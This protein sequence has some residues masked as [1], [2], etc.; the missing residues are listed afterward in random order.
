MG[1][2][3]Y[4]NQSCEAVVAAFDGNC[5]ALIQ[6]WP[7]SDLCPAECGQCC[8]EEEACNTNGEGSCEYAEE[9]FDCDGNCNVEIDCAGVCGGVSEVDCTGVCGGVY[10]VDCNGE[11]GGDA[12]LD[13]CNVCDPDNN[14][15]NQCYGC[16]ADS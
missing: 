6:Y 8:D 3:S 10:E 14:N 9:N 5:N 16:C 13:G 7:L 12:Y 1:Y 2:F 11:C 4:W 15:N